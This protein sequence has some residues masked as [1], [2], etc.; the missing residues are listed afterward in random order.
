MAR[1]GESALSMAISSIGSCKD[2]TARSRLPGKIFKDKGSVAD[3]FSIQG[4]CI[5]VKAM[6]SIIPKEEK[7]QAEHAC[8]FSF[9]HSVAFYLRFIIR[10]ILWCSQCTS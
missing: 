10:S 5:F 4:V 2:V 3:T 8:H 9:Q 1:M 7:W 6:L